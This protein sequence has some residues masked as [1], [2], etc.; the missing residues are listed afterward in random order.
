MRVGD[1]LRAMVTLEEQMLA[2]LSQHEDAA[3]RDACAERLLGSARRMAEEHLAALRQRLSD[4]ANGPA[5]GLVWMAPLPATPPSDDL[6]DA[7][8]VRALTA[9]CAAFHHMAS[10]YSVLHAL[11]HRA[12]DSDREGNTADLAELHLR[13][14]ARAAQEVDR[15]ISEVVVSRLDATGSGCRCQCPS[16]ELGLCICAPH[17]AITVGKAWRETGP[18]PDA[19]GIAVRPPRTGSPAQ[20][21]GLR[22]G[23]RI[24]AVEGT[25]LATDLDAPALQAAVRRRAPGESVHL[26]ALRAGGERTPVDLLRP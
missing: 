19:P 16:C 8:P 11:A 6:S 14:Y 24:V 15:V 23:D 7:S 5:G 22:A 10:A 13:G 26:L 12:A 9:C 25:D 4:A 17:G 20:Q 3:R 18:E 2:L 1:S 21:A